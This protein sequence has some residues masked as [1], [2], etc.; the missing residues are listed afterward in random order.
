MAEPMHSVK[1]YLTVLVALIVLTI[2]TVAVSFVPLEGHWHL[3]AGVGIAVL[4]A[5]LVAVFFM[6]LF[7]GPRVVVLTAI[8]ACFWLGILGVLSFSD[9]LTRG[10]W[11]SVPGH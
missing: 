9:Y 6:H 3:A 8:V 10:E 1:T 7:A 2:A 11:P 4:K 5:S